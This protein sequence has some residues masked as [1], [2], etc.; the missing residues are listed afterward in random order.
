MPLPA[1]IFVIGFGKPSSRKKLKSKLVRL[2]KVFFH[3]IQRKSQ[4]VNLEVK[5]IP[6]PFKKNILTPSHLLPFEKKDSA[7]NEV[8]IFPLTV[9]NIFG[10]EITKYCK[11]GKAFALIIQS[12]ERLCTNQRLTCSW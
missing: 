11:E 5:Q 2:S 10:W 9:E 6:S 7:M 3:E 4:I 8:S 1:L 12:A